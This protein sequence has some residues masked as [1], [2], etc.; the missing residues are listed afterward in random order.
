M[1]PSLIL[2]GRTGIKGKGAPV[3]GE[4][5]ALSLFWQS[6]QYAIPP[7]IQN[8]RLNT[9]AVFDYLSPTGGDKDQALR[10]AWLAN[11]AKLDYCLDILDPQN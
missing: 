7:Q 1:R 5:G 2:H 3:L 10:I 6:K 11:R 8:F 9:S 4:V